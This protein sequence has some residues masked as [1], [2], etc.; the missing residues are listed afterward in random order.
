MR[1]AQFSG[2]WESRSSDLGIFPPS[3]RSPSRMPRHSKLTLESKQSPTPGTL[4]GTPSPMTL[5]LRSMRLTVSLEFEAL[6]G[7]GSMDHVKSE[8][9]R[10][11]ENSSSRCV[12]SRSPSGQ[13]GLSARCVLPL[14]T[15]GCSQRHEEPSKAS[16][17]LNRV[18]RMDLATTRICISRKTGGPVPN[19]LRRKRTLEVIAAPQRG[20]WF[21]C[22]RR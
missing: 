17:R 1:S 9:R 5:V 4:A 11:I 6:V 7:L 14:R 3:L 22:W 13:L 16:S 2:R 21:L 8:M 10:T 19:S 20:R 18:A 12:R 15:A